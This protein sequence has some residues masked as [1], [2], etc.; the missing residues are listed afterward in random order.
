MFEISR[1]GG[2]GMKVYIGYECD[3]DYANTWRNAVKVFDDE[4][5]ALAWEEEIEKT[6]LEWRSYEQFEVE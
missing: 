4:A 6:D 5:K 3:Y 2:K 1:T